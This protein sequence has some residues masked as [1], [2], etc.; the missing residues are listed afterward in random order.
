MSSQV[1]FVQQDAGLAGPDQCPRCRLQLIDPTG[2]GWC[3]GCGFCRSLEDERTNELL[4][5]TQARGPQ[6]SMGMVAGH[7]PMWSWVLVGGIVVAVAASLVIGYLLPAGSNFIRAL[8]TTVQVAVALLVIFICQ[9]LALVQIAAEDEKLGFKD[10]LMPTRLWSLVCK[11]LPATAASLWG[12]TWAL[13]LIIGALLFIGGLGH[14][15]EYLPGVK[16]K[17]KQKQERGRG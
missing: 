4:Q 12:A 15:N 2:L 9:L 3:R 7:I 5:K 11:R 17:Q 6:V 14:W 13:A 10:A 8:W 1:D 16:D